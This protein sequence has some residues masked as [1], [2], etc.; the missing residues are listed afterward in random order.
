MKA[1]IALVGLTVLVMAGLA[2]AGTRPRVSN[3]SPS[4]SLRLSGP[5]STGAGGIS[6]DGGLIVSAGGVILGGFINSNQFN[7]AG[8]TDGWNNFVYQIV[9]P[10]EG[11]STGHGICLETS[12][13]SAG[14]M[15][16]AS[17]IVHTTLPNQN[18]LQIMAN[19]LSSGLATVTMDGGRPEIDTINIIG[20]TMTLGSID[21]GRQITTHGVLV[22]DGGVVANGIS[23]LMGASTINTTASYAI[24]GGT[25][26]INSTAVGNAADTTEDNLITYSLPAN[27]LSV[28]N[29]AVRVTTWGSGVST[30]DAT[31]VKCY[32]GATAV[33][34][35]ILTA[36]QA[37]TW[38]ATFE[39]VRTGATAQIAT[40]AFINGGTVVTSVQS[41][42]SPGETLSGAVTIKCTGQRAVTSSANSVQQLGMVTEFFN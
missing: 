13:T 11:D 31:T 21:V 9:I 10:Y 36:S 19:G 23:N 34:T 16:C 20:R 42:A 27:A 5:V 37:N 1:R 28:N 41:N 30:A 2:F 6:T 40:G 15:F 7:G 25:A 33:L 8:L 26:N 18:I 3:G 22:A 35:R 32:F 38:R 4:G 39:V 12:Y 24:T 14:K 29:K 17:S